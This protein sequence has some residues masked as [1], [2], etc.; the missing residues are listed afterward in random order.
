MK[1]MVLCLAVLISLST[2]ATAEAGWRCRIFKKRSC[3]SQ[4]RCVPK[5]CQPKCCE[6]ACAEPDG[7]GDEYIKLRTSI[8]DVKKDIESLDK[9]VE[10]MQNE[11]KAH[12]NKMEQ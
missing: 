5:N 4:R 9:K 1:K 6:P 10:S 7:P 8:K 3:V 11:L 12:R 2:F